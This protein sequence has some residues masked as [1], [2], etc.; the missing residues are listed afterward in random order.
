MAFEST[1][2][3][4][5]KKLREEYA[6]KLPEGIASI[7]QAWDVLSKTWQVDNLNTFH[8]RVHK[9]AGAAG[10]FGFS[11]LSHAAREL[12]VFLQQLQHRTTEATEIEITDIKQYLKAMRSA[13][14]LP[15][16][17]ESGVKSERNQVA[18]RLI[19]L[20]D[21]DNEL[22]SFL[23]LQLKHHGYDVRIFNAVDDVPQAVRKKAPNALL[24][25]I[26]LS[27]DDLAGPRMIYNIQRRRA[28]PLPVIFMSARVD[29]KARL[30]SVRANGDAYFTKPV[31]VE[32]MIMVM[33]RLTR[34]PNPDPYRVLIVDDTGRYAE[35]YASK[36]R[37]AD[38]QVKTLH[39]PM[40]FMNALDVFSPM[41]IMIHTKLSAGMSGLE[42][43][44]IIQQHNRYEHPPI[45]F[46]ADEFD[47]IAQQAALRG[48]GEDFITH[49]IDIDVLV[50]KVTHRIKQS[51]ALKTVEPITVQSASRAQRDRLTGLYR[52]KYM[53]DQVEIASKSS[54][55]ENRPCLLYIKLDNYSGIDKILGLSA[56]EAVLIETARFL[57]N[58]VKNQELVARVSDSVFVILTLNRPL[59]NV[60]ALAE[61]IRTTLENHV[62]EAEDERVLSTCSI[63]ISLCQTQHAEHP[64]IALEHAERA[65]RMIKSK[66][67]NKI[68]LHDSA[69]LQ[70]QAQQQQS[71]WEQTI[72]LALEHNNFYLSYQPITHLHGESQ[73][74]YDV[75]LR[76]P[77]PETDESEYIAPNVFLPRAEETGQITDIDRWVAK[78]SIINLMREH[79]KGQRLN[80]FIRISG[81]SMLDDSFIPWLQECLRVAEIALDTL[82]FDLSQITLQEHLKEAQHFTQ[83][84]KKMGC[85]IALS[86]YDGQGASKQLL[87]LLQPHF[88]KLEAPLIKGLKSASE[89]EI[90]K[91]ETL[92]SEAHEHQCLVIAPFVEDIASL[93]RL[94]QSRV[95]YTAG[96]FV[97]SPTSH[98]D[99]DFD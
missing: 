18:G 22:A 98:L 93:N 50:A 51:Q 9:I 30:A 62:I 25:D 59:N 79:Y 67:G 96:Q 95:D 1:L 29:M 56:T 86:H 77:N 37:E 81:A 88:I 99:Y 80:F 46:F 33:D 43:A 11:E 32:A 40:Q 13:A 6:T 14:K 87:K 8:A 78:E 53:L 4:T 97:E 21:D 10:S 91:L 83:V 38:I 92:V 75:L 73:H 55:Y 28:N 17:E 63:G 68:L 12:E 60:K 94:W 65:C 90:Q 35:Q 31:D 64:E 82:I 69:L 47:D 34:L 71:Y 85:R 70:K 41:L 16:K 72:R 48:I 20:V 49:D 2:E 66:G 26:M 23:E 36:L 7:E 84:L 15:D 45:L 58:Q 61:L 57:K 5:L 76:M 19:Y 74:F 52:R 42:L 24:M 89:E 39:K 27:E 3:I 54:E 44:L